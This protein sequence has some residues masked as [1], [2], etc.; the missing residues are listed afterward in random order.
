MLKIWYDH[1]ASFF[2]KPWKAFYYFKKPWERGY[3]QLNHGN[4]I[5]W[6]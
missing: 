6:K 5:M 4:L 1:R 3:E 2:K